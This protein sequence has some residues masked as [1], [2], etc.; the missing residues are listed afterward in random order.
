MTLEQLLID[1]PLILAEGSVAEQVRRGQPHLL[2]P[3]LVHTLLVRS[4]EG[5]RVLEELFTSY[6]GVA[7]SRGLPIIL[8]TPTWRANP[9]RLQGISGAERING[10]CAEF[11]LGIKAKNK[12]V[13][14]MVNGLIGS[15]NDC[16]KPGEAPGATEAEAFHRWQAKKLAAGGVDF[17]IAETLP[18]VGE[19]L[20]LARAMAETKLPYVISFVLSPEG[21]IMDG[22][23]LSEAIDVIDNG[24][25]IPPSGY[26]V[27]CCY[28]TFLE[29]A[30]LKEADRER[31][32]GIQA[33]GS[34]LDPRELESSTELKMEPVSEWVEAMAR[35]KE[36]GL[37][38]I[39][40]GCCGTSPEHIEALAARLT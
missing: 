17:L 28:P 9:Q 4:P 32:L 12:D 31:F 39:F 23:T 18:S 36:S 16:Y 20:G 11:L 38:K 6:I 26:M 8:S 25:P 27:N 30:A 37:G 21:T 34:A 1:M 7:R 14:V 33:N 13:E 2:H 35:L 15:K 19:A 22:T 40:G 5:R 10:E 24:A 29:R 3:T